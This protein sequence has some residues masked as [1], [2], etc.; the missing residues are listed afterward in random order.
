MKG[1]PMRRSGTGNLSKEFSPQFYL[2]EHIK[3]A[4]EAVKA[5]E[6]AVLDAVNFDEKASTLLAEAY[7]ALSRLEQASADEARASAL[8]PVACEMKVHSRRACMLVS[9]YSKK[10]S[11]A[12]LL[13]RCGWGGGDKASVERKF[14]TCLTHLKELAPQPPAAPGD[15]V[16]S[17]SVSSTVGATVS[18]GTVAMPTP[19]QT[20]PRASV[21]FAAGATLFGVAQP[22]GMPHAPTVMTGASS[23]AATSDDAVLVMAPGGGTAGLRVQMHPQM[24]A[25]SARGSCG[26]A[27]TVIDRSDLTLVKLVGNGAF[28][29]VWLAEWIGIQVAAKE[30]QGFTSGSDCGAEGQGKSAEGF[31]ATVPPKFHMPIPVPTTTIS[32]NR[33]KRQHARQPQPPQCDALHGSVPRPPMIVTQYYQHRSLFELLKRARRGDGGALRAMAWTKRLMVR[34]CVCVGAMRRC[35]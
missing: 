11:P 4:K 12:D 20:L 19:G 1:S 35:W 33:P 25:S 32:I 31:S 22:S 23:D 16:A 3:E 10:Y 9:L 34:A 5:L 24:L 29:K 21:P 14:D 15:V 6:E 8:I 27:A 30:L 13:C 2:K 26:S 18:P 17:A 28:S 7:R